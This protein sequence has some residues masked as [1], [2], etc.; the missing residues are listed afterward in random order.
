[1]SKKFISKKDAFKIICTGLRSENFSYERGSLMDEHMCRKI[2][3]SLR[4]TKYGFRSIIY[5]I[6]KKNDEFKRYFFEVGLKEFEYPIKTETMPTLKVLIQ[7][8]EIDQTECAY[9]R[10]KDS[11]YSRILKELNMKDNLKN[12][13]RIY[14][15]WRKLQEFSSSSASKLTSSTPRMTRSLSPVLSEARS[16]HLESKDDVIIS[17]HTAEYSEIPSE[18]TPKIES[19][20]YHSQILPK[21]NQIPKYIL[22]LSSPGKYPPVLPIDSQNEIMSHRKNLEYKNCTFLEGSFTLS[23]DI[24]NLIFD[25]A[26]RLIKEYYPYVIRNRIRKYVNNVC[27][28]IFKYVVYSK[29]TTDVVVF[30]LCKHNKYGCKKFKILVNRRNRAVKVYS[31]SLNYTHKNYLAR[32]IKGVERQ[33]FKKRLVNIRPSALKKETLLL[34]SQSG[35]PLTEGKNLQDVVSDVTLR[36]IKYESH[37]ALIRDK[38]DLYDIMLMQQDDVDF[39]REVSLPLNIK[40]FSIEQLSVL[41]SETS[42]DSSSYIHFDATGGII[43]RPKILKSNK[44][45]YFY[46]AVI[47][48]KKAK[49]I[50]PIFSMISEIHNSNAIFKLFSDFRY[51]CEENNFWPSFSGIVTDFSFANIHAACKAF[52]RCS[53][54]EY[55][56]KCYKLAMQDKKITGN[57][58]FIGIHLCCAHFMKMMCKDVD[59]LSKCEEQRIYFKDQLAIAILINNIND[60]LTFIKNIYVILMSPFLNSAVEVAQDNLRLLSTSECLE[61]FKFHNVED[62]TSEYF[63]YENKSESLSRSSP[64]YLHIMQN[65]TKQINIESSGNCEN[66]LY[67]TDLYNLILNKYIPY[68]PL[69]SGIVLNCRSISNCYV[70]TYFG[71]LKNITLEGQRNIRCSHFIRK[72]RDDTLS[73]K[74]EAELGITK[75]RLTKEDPSEEK[76]SQETWAKKERRRDTSHFRGRFLRRIKPHESIEESPSETLVFPEDDADLA[77]CSHCGKG[78]PNENTT[79]ILCDKCDRWYHKSCTNLGIHKDVSQLEFVCVIC[80]FEGQ[81]N[82]VSERSLATDCHD[83]VNKLQ[84]SYMDLKDL[85]VRTRGQSECALWNEERKIRLTASFFGRICKMRKNDSDSVSGITKSIINPRK[86]TTPPVIHGKQCE[87]P[88][89]KLYEQKTQRVCREV[90]LFVYKKYQ[91]LAASPDGLIGNEGIIEIKSPYNFRNSDPNTCNF[92][93]LHPDGSLKMTHDYYYQIQGQLEITNRLWCDLIIYT[94]KGIRIIRISRNTKF[95]KNMVTKLKSFY[96]FSLLPCIINPTN[97][98]L[99]LLDRKWTT[100]GDLTFLPNSLVDDEAYYKELSNK[101]SYVVTCDPSIYFST[102]QVMI[103]DF[104]TLNPKEYVSSFVID[105]CLNIFNKENGSKYQI[106][107]VAKASLIFSEHVL[108]DYFLNSISLEKDNSLVLP[109]YMDNSRHYVLIIVHFSNRKITILDSLGCE[110]IITEMLV[111]RLGEFLLHKNTAITNFAIES[112]KHIL[113][114]DGFNCGIYVIHFFRCLATETALDS[115]VDINSERVNLKMILLRSS[116]DMSELCI[117]CSTKIFPNQPVFKCRTCRRLIHNKCLLTAKET[118]EGV[119]TNQKIR[120]GICDICR[121]N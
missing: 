101:R 6:V 79:W 47:S 92:D 69:W 34:A 46:T 57:D 44:R 74:T 38:D 56:E 61:A 23:A 9:Y 85:E 107:S 109:I 51:F 106:I 3:A 84:K 64:F 99:P 97:G 49:R 17:G 62:S 27:I 13:L 32:E 35:L 81:D 1:M 41:K 29:K 113:Q 10:R 82:A 65:V 100:L 105:H 5:K 15:E 103:D 98:S 116:V 93:F 120:N 73:L 75:N 110:S 115:N 119:S 60:C 59:N 118:E 55:L 54:K 48:L 52:N 28:I 70:E 39:I 45:I 53:L 31:T 30:A 16:D 108:N 71:Q 63:E 25:D 80:L 7:N 88:A 21:C 89:R 87:I 86:L 102:A 66:K 14:K 37:N 78:I 8:L 83:F 43:R 58:G 42:K 2:L 22:N 91:F 26:G 50:F 77:I 11:A 90:G 112:P 24:I 4:G 111:R 96:L 68:L 114:Q 33:I 18:N 94:F 19:E 121:L 95:W 67:N 117:F 12:R 76:L 36:K 20:N 72:L 104:L 40:L